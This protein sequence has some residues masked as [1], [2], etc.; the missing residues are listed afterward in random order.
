MIKH[1]HITIA[2]PHCLGI[3]EPESLECNE[4][5]AVLSDSERRNLAIAARGIYH[6]SWQYGIAFNSE[7][8]E[9]GR[10]QSRYAICPMDVL[11]Y[12]ASIIAAGVIGNFAYDVLKTLALRTIARLKSHPET[13]TVIDP[14]LS[15]EQNLQLLVEIAQ[16]YVEHHQTPFAKQNKYATVFLTIEFSELGQ[17]IAPELLVELEEIYSR[18]AK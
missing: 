17:F 12:L 5:H 18:H 10:I 11:S 15:D 13:A 16:A 1:A 2:C 9:S 3:V 4:C 14:H 8:E 6:W 7:Y